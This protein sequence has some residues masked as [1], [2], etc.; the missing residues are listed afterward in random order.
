MISSQENNNDKKLKEQQVVNR[1]D[2]KKL[3]LKDNKLKESDNTSTENHYITIKKNDKFIR[4]ILPNKVSSS[5]K[6]LK[7]ETLNNDDN[8]KNS[9]LCPLVK[10]SSSELASNEL[11]IKHHNSKEELKDKIVSQ[12]LNKKIIETKVKQIESKRMLDK[13]KSFSNIK[14]KIKSNL[15]DKFN[16]SNKKN[17]LHKASV[18]TKSKSNKAEKF[19]CRVIKKK[20]TT[21]N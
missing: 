15:I 13:L 5:N 19:Q 16:M 14:Q 4:K 8:V 6:A 20:K 2:N 1:S 18:K 12:D 7:K 3:V 17:L 9:S 11:T 10:S 21:E